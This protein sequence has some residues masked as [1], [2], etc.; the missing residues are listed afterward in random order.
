MKMIAVI[1]VA[2]ILAGAAG[3]FMGGSLFR[4]APPSPDVVAETIPEAEAPPPPLYKMPL[5]GFTMRV[6]RKERVVHLVVDLDLFMLG[7]TDFGKMN[8]ALGKTRLRDAAVTAFAGLAESSRWSDPDSFAIHD[9]RLLE[10]DIVRKLHEDFPM[11]VTARF[12]Q[13]VTSDSLRD[14]KRMADLAQSKQ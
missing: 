9:K 14:P 2:V 13:F 4:E 8:G 10:E 1:A 6:A 3:F 12:N 11:V 7:A 5:G